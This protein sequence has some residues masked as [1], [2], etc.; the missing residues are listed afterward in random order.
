MRLHRS[1]SFVLAGAIALAVAAPATANRPQD[2]KDTS[3]DETVLACGGDDGDTITFNS[4]RTLWPPNHKYSPLSVTATDDGDDEEL[5]LSTS[6]THDEYLNDF[7]PS[8]ESSEQE[9]GDNELNGSGNTVNDARPFMAMAME[10]ES[11]GAESDE[12]AVGDNQARTTHEIRAERSGRSDGRTY[13]IS[14]T[15]MDGGETECEGEFT[16]E[17]PHD[18]RSDKAPA[19][20]SVEE[21]GNGNGRKVATGA[22]GA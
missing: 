6:V 19:A 3:R 13:T 4:D 5:V 22:K 2:A 7:V 12:P 20:K 16:V 11:N 8:N 18:M 17:V 9:Q 15:V 21:R 14:Y 1:T 10:G